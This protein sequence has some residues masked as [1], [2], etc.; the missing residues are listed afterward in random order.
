MYGKTN[1]SIKVE[2]T[3]E[4]LARGGKI[5]VYG[6]RESSKRKRTRKSR[7]VDAQALLNAATGTDEEAEVVTFLKS[8]GICIE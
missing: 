2:T 7:T 1:D 3:K 5:E 6:E 4:F 8:Q